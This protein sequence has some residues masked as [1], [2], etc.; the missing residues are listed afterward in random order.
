E[1]KEEDSP[2]SVSL[3]V[4]GLKSDL[5]R[6]AL[7]DS[8]RAY[9]RLHAKNGD[10]VGYYSRIAPS[11]IHFQEAIEKLAVRYIYVKNYGQ[12]VKLL[13][14][15]SER[16]SD[17]QRVVNIYREVLMMIP[18]RSRA[19]IPVQEMAFVLE[20]YQRWNSYFELSPKT[21]QDAHDFFEKQI[22]ELATR[23]HS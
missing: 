10:P 8:I 9:T 15:L 17:P 18:I 11:E 1:L 5:K 2:Y 20:Q 22:R 16:T 13:R 6:E 12:A 14:T 19:D 21:R 7:I 3:K 23:N 4:K